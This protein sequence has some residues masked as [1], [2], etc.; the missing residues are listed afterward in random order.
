MNLIEH[1][2]QH[3]RE[4]PD[5]KIIYPIEDTQYKE[6]YINRFYKIIKET[7]THTILAGYTI[8]NF[9]DS[10][11]SMLLDYKGRLY[12]NVRYTNS[13]IIVFG[14]LKEQDH[15][16]VKDLFLPLREYFA[17][18]SGPKIISFFDSL[19]F[20]DRSLKNDVFH[21]RNHVSAN[22]EEHIL[23]LDGNDDIKLQKKVISFLKYK[24][25]TKEEW[26]E[27]FARKPHIV[28]L[29]GDEIVSI[30][31]TNTFSD[32]I[33]VIGGVYTPPEHRRKGYSSAVNKAFAAYLQDKSK[34]VALET[35]HTNLA[36]QKVYRKIGYEVVG[37]SAFFQRDV[38][39]I[40]DQLIGDRDY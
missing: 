15:E 39:I 36:A 9:V 25:Q 40:E 12:F 18:V 26:N 3:Y 35:D 30:A 32:D 13:Q 16:F 4:H 5:L 8:G 17:F 29:L 2:L 31:R 14:D 37:Q 20:Y 22:L 11:G 34:L 7:P 23:I 38:N 10:P 1:I 27:L 28:Y 6:G 24:E 19:D 33:A 21:L